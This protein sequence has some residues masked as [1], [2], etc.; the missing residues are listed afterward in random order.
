VFD[1]AFVEGHLGIWRGFPESPFVKV[2]QGYGVMVGAN[3]ETADVVPYE[4]A[5]KEKVSLRDSTMKTK[6]WLEIEHD[7]D[8]F[9]SLRTSKGI[10]GGERAKVSRVV[11]DSMTQFLPGVIVEV[12]PLHFYRTEEDVRIAFDVDDAMEGL[13][14]YDRVDHEVLVEAIRKVIGKESAE[15]HASPRKKSAGA[16]PKPAARKRAVA[17]TTKKRGSK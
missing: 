6:N 8:Y 16:K 5:M 3:A 15:E 4:A 14:G 12:G 10:L 11:L 7:G 17:A 13:H 9:V 2:L 1:E